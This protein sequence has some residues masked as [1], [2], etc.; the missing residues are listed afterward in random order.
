MSIQSITTDFTNKG[1]KLLSQLGNNNDSI[2]P[3]LVKDS[4]ANGA[5][6]YT[7]SKE[8][9][10]DDAREKAIEG[11]GTGAVWLLMIPALKWVIDKTVYP[12]FK[13]NPNFWD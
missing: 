11:F 10:K 9:G 5:V 13:L 1:I 8:G 4:M 3:M 6:V 12:F 2:V 7:Y